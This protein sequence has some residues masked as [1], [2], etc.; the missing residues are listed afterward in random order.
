VDVSE[1]DYGEGGAAAQSF[2]SKLTIELVAMVKP[3]EPGGS[4]F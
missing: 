4:A 1:M 2:F 3:P